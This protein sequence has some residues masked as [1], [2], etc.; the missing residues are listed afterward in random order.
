MDNEGVGSHVCCNA[1]VPTMDDE[2]AGSHVCLNAPIF[3]LWMMRGWAHTYAAIVMLLP[4]PTM[5]NE[6]AGSHVC[7]NA[8][9]PTMDD[10]GVG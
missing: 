4:S 3:Q 7:C 6:G 10:E 1:P 8:P 9:I 2:G 5:D